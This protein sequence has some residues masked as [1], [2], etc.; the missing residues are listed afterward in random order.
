MK[1]L[2]NDADQLTFAVNATETAKIVA[3]LGLLT[4]LGKSDGP[5]ADAAPAAKESLARVLALVRGEVVEP[6]KE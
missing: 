4:K 5:L 6:P 1:P 3:V 2:F